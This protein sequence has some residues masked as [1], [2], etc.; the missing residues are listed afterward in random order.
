MTTKI[1]RRCSTEKPAVEFRFDPRYRDGLA[2][3]CKECHRQRNS[4]W[5]RENRG[6]LT[7]KATAY[8]AEHLEQARDSNR[9]F[10]RANSDR[11]QAQ[12]RVWALSNKD[13]RRASWAAHKA[14]KLQA[15]PPWA[16]LKAIALVYRLASQ[17]ET[18]TGVRMHVDHIVPLQHPLVC[19]LH[20]PANLQILPGCFNEAKRNHWPLPPH[21]SIEAALKQPD[22]FIE[23]PKPLKQQALL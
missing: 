5:A 14:S 15:T 8:R 13:R 3:W 11:L 18:V 16:D 19:G 10:K 23:A 1:C 4:V 17:A 9:R 12:N 7:A 2:S 6:R 20:V 22:M 21:L